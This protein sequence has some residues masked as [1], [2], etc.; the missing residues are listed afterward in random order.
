MRSPAGGDDE[1]QQRGI[2]GLSATDI[3]SVRIVGVTRGLWQ[4]GVFLS[5][6]MWYTARAGGRAVGQLT[7][8]RGGITLDG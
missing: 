8:K 2:I 3:C 6:G 7:G 4:R 1:A 5:I